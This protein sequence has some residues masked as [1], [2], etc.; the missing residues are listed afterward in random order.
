VPFGGGAHKC[1]G[2]F[3]GEMEV[4]AILHQMLL[5]YRWSVPE[6]YEMPQDYTSLPIPK[7][8]LPIRLEPLR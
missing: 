7:D 2:L 6:G 5:R 8:H 4:K 1:I 3:F